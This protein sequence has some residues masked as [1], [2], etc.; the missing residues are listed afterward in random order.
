MFMTATTTS[1]GAQFEIL[2]SIDPAYHQW[3]AILTQTQTQVLEMARVFVPPA[4]VMKELCMLA[5]VDEGWEYI[6]HLLRL[7]FGT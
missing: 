3:T 6:Q 2:A 5:S 1:D 4:D 7:H